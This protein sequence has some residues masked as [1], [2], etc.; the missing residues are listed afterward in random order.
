MEDIH[1]DCR[2]YVDWFTE[3]EWKSAQY[4]EWTTQEQEH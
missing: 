1:A 3:R 2:D 4:L